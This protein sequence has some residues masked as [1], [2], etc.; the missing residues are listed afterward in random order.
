MMRESGLNTVV[1]L[2]DLGGLPAAGGGAVR[3]GLFLRSA[4]LNR[5]S[6]RDAR[7]LSERYRVRAVID[8]RTGTERGEKPDR[9]LPGA[10]YYHIP[11]FSEATMGVT[12]EK[13]MDRREAL[14]HL[15]DL[16]GLYEKMVTDPFCTSQLRAVFALL[17]DGAPGAALF[18]CTAGKD[19]AGT[20]AALLLTLLG[21]PAEAVRAD[22]LRSN[23]ALKRTAERYYR[24]VLL[25]SRNKE[26]AMRVK[27]LYSADAAMLS[28]LFGAIDRAYGGFEAFRRDALGVTDDALSALK[29]RAVVRPTRRLK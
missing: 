24:L 17:T 15:P 22:Y 5:L 16:G 21:A 6:A 4:A 29:N 10:R 14:D 25:L 8:L 9:L 1:N 18:H 11:I 3:P 13:G 20:V 27:T 23:A 19:R 7:T 28:R 26:T 2:R 12:H